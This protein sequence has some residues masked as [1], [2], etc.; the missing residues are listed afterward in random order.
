SDR[1]GPGVDIVL[2]AGIAATT[3]Q[4]RA[5]PELKVDVLDELALREDLSAG[6]EARG[7]AG[8]DDRAPVVDQ[9]ALD[10]GRMELAVLG[11]AEALADG[12]LGLRVAHVEARARVQRDTVAVSSA[13][14]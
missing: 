8:G 5:R 14:S 3:G 4:Q 9:R 11:L 13:V 1:P 7:R 2:I 12:E 6:R 10:A